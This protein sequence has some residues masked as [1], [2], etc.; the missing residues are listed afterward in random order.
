MA[1]KIFKD[2]WSNYFGKDNAAYLINGKTA[3]ETALRQLGSYCVAMPTY[4]C[5]RVYE[6][7]LNTHCKPRIVDCDYDL[8]IDEKLVENF[9][10][11][12]TVIVPHMFGIQAQK[13][14]KYL[15]EKGYMII[16]DCSQCLGLEGLGKYSDIVI[17]SLGPTK[18]LPSGVDKEKGG[19]VIAYNGSDVEWH[20][21]PTAIHRT[22][23]MF[24]DIDK[25]Y[26]G[27]KERV[28]EIRNTGL[29][30]I[31]DNKPNS[32]LRAMYFT[33]NQKRVPYTPL[34]D[35][36]N[37]TKWLGEDVNF[38]CPKVDSIKNNLEWVSVFP[39][40]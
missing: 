15:K 30:F 12:D 20:D 13:Q 32:W 21:N 26:N 31:G 18:W 24:Q 9:K 11:V 38:D 40:V 17:A 2:N 8:Q 5:H 10:D 23:V 1:T 14:I 34:H 19:A 27:R 36:Y 33:Q 16:E 25:I 4:T 7:T 28:D 37:G 39:N 6:A 35:K 29:R 3:I 22:N